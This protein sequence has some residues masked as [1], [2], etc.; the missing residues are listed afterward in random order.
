[1]NLPL[2]GADDIEALG[3]TGAVDAL[4]AALSG[5]LD[6]ETSPAR[7]HVTVPGG[8]LLIMPAT[9]QRVTG[10]KI[11]GVA[12]GNPARDLP[13]ITGSYL[14]L[15]GPTLLPLA[16]LDGAALTT[17]RTPA[18]SALA[19]RHLTGPVLRHLVLFG[20]GPQAYGHLA[21]VLAERHVERVTVIGRTPLRVAALVEH[22]RELGVDAR[23]GTAHGAAEVATADLVLCCT[24]SATPLF[25]GAL[26]PDGATVVAVGSH[27]PDAREVD[28]TLVSRSSVIVESRAAALSEA[29]DL[30]IPMAEGAFSAED[31]A[32]NLADLVSGLRLGEQPAAFERPRFF[33]SVGMGWEDLAVAAAVHRKAAP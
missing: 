12:P 24:T 1:M 31:I 16:L 25:D 21:A 2:L 22:A 17:L 10:V 27:T 15:D 9:T 32:G 19:I 30:L 4:E 26:V 20:T 5:G 23:A 8:E 11:A 29:G 33:K 18:V 13:R 28:T 7:H 6:P 14:L 3:P